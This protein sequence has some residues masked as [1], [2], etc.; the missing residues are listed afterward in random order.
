MTNRIAP[1][2]LI[3]YILGGWL[4]PAAHYHGH[5]ANV[6]GIG[7]VPVLHQHGGHCGHSPRTATEASEAPETCETPEACET[8]RADRCSSGLAGCGGDLGCGESTD[9]LTPAPVDTEQPPPTQL[10][11]AT[12]NDCCIGLCA[13][14][15]A[16]TLSSEPAAFGANT[17]R[18]SLSGERISIASQN[19]HV[20]RLL[21]SISSRGPPIIL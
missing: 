12:Y 3:A 13:L 16:R 19:V 7:A 6:A 18:C 15:S 17:A 21:G 20:G 9:S 10:E 8:H 1:I 11:A 2:A 14:C 5:P 4:L